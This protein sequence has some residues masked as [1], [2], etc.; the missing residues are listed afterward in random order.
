MQPAGL[1]AHE[2]RDPAK[3]NRYS[4]ENRGVTLDPDL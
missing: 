1:A 3:Q 4:F 2:T